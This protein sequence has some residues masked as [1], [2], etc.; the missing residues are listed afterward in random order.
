MIKAKIK[1]K[2]EKK[3][4]KIKETLA[5]VFALVAIAFLLINSLYLLVFKE[6]IIG[7]VIQ[8]KTIQEFGIENLSTVTNIILIIFVAIW[9]VIAVVMA[10]TIYYVETKKWKWYWLLVISIISFFTARIDTAVFGI[11]SSILYIKR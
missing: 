6:K 2:K 1:Y 5:L 4:G 3:K 10:F 9:F 7:E 8:D 11:I